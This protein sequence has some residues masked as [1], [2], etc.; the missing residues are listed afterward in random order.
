MA[1]SLSLSQKQ[2][3]KLSPQLL[4]SFE[5]MALPL[6]EL[7]QKIKAEIEINPALEIPS[8]REASFEVFAEKNQDTE[9]IND[10]YSDSSSYGSD[11]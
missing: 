6:A 3:L 10:S 8:G 7:Q 4:Q 1:L 11:K 9:K 2:Q 5:L